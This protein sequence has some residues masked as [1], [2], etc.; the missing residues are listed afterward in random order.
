MIQRK[1]NLEISAKIESSSDGKKVTCWEYVVEK[2]VQ[3]LLCFVRFKKG[4]F[5]SL[6]KNMCQGGSKSPLKTFQKGKLNLTMLNSILF[7][8]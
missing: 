2:E 6:Q 7:K 3:D 4:D 5:K 8:I 1:N